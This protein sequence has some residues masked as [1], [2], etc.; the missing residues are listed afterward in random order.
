MADKARGEHHTIIQAI[1]I[2]P[3]Y[4]HQLLTLQLMVVNQQNH[5]SSV[6]QLCPQTLVL[7][8]PYLKLKGVYEVRTK[9]T[10]ERD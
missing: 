2:V 10:L 8:R 6:F 5:H 3:Y 7:S 4:Y 9:A 1:A